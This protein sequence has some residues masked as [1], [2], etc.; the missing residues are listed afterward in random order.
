MVTTHKRNQKPYLV[1]RA[2]LCAD[3]DIIGLAS[4]EGQKVPRFFF[5]GTIENRR[6]L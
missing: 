2:H 5:K 3:L 6:G 1:F 4:T